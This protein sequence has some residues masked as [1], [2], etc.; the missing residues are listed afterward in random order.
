MDFNQTLVVAIFASTIAALI[1]TNKRPSS[2]FAVSLL[3]L[4]LGQQLS[5]NEV[6]NNLTNQ[7]LITLILLLLV[8]SAVDKTSLIKR[9]GRTLITANYAQSYWRMFVLTFFSS[10][11]LN[12]TAVVASLIG[13]VKQN[14][15]HPSSKLLIPLSYIAILGGTVTLIGTST[16]LIVD[17]FLIDHGHPGFN[18]WDFTL[19]GLVAGLSC[20]LL[21]FMLTPW[22]P[23]IENKNTKYNCYFIEAKVAADSE[24]VGKSVEQNHLRNLPELF[25]VEVIRAKNL[26]SP[27]SPD[28]IIQ[29]DDKLIFSGNAQNVGNLGHIKGLNLFAESNGLLRDNLTEV[30][31]SNRAQIIGYSLKTL[32]FRAL[33]DAAVVAIRRDGESLSGKLGEIK[34]QAGDFLL[35]ATGPDF[36]QRRNLTK[37]FF[38]LSEKKMPAKLSLWQERITLGGFIG[39]VS[40]AAASVLPLATGLVF[41]MAL[42]IATGVSNTNELKGNLPLN[43][44]IVIVGALSLATGLEKAGVIEHLTEI[45]A[46]FAADVSP[47]TALVV[48]YVLTLL[49][50]EAVTN[51]A[52]AA[53]MFPF[54]FGITQVLNVDLMPF[55]LAVAFAASASFMS[56]Y[57]YQTN[58]LVFSATNYK[59]K[60]FVKIGLPVSIC[61]SAI[62][63]LLLKLTYPL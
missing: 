44:I 59:F 4:I 58:L 27:V 18:F 12:N 33:F 63:L 17:S 36:L 46:P 53:L 24:L 11:L 57:G 31:I 35:L 23:T 22:L 25:L 40:L 39:V 20:G 7:G 55:A 1:L 49:L 28:L 45:L 50:T 61:Y 37:N 48:V 43:L 26:I 3:A 38:V 9:L 54:A 32:G 6:I 16:N 5:L 42:L 56:P 21:I 30:I 14:Q 15:Y 29:A 13:P 47:F 19:Y 51:N 52:A 34:L 8:S 62:V 2:I 60:H 41:L 10:A